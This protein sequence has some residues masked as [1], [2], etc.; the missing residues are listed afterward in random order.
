MFCP[1]C[2]A[3]YWEGFR[4]CEECKVFLVEEPPLQV[5]PRRIV[6]VTVMTSG[7]ATLLAIAKSLMQDAG[8]YYYAKGEGLQD[9]FGLGRM[10]FG[11]NPLVGPIELQV[12]EERQ[13]EARELLAKLLEEEVEKP[14]FSV[15]GPQ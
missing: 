11:F 5:D 2:G 10:G 15:I 14:K 3:E 4:I 9:L 12:E 1:D 13:E 7:D 8:I 6:F